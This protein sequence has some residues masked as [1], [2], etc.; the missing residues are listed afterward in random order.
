[1][2]FRPALLST[3]GHCWSQHTLAS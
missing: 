2:R 1:M 3:R